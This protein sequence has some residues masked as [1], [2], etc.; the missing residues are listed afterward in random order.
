MSNHMRFRCGKRTVGSF[1]KVCIIC[2]IVCL[3]LFTAQYGIKQMMKWL[4][5]L[6][7]SDLVT[8]ASLEYSVPEDVIYSVIRTESSFRP[9]AVSAA[10]AVGLMQLM[11]ETFEWLLTLMKKELPPDAIYY[12]DVNIACG[13]YYLAYLKAELGDWDTVFAAYNAGIGRVKGWL[14]DTNISEQGT[15]VN[16]PIEETAKYVIKIAKTRDIYQK[17]YN[18]K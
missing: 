14:T 1:L 5:P 3:T 8:Q 10:G 7:Y 4:Y 16:I 12:P 11:P 13:V 17:L 18:F 6:K 2:M 15:L 9:E